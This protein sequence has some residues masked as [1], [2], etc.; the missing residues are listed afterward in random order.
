MRNILYKLVVIKLTLLFVASP[1]W[2]EN[3]N[4]QVMLNTEKG[5]IVVELFPKQAPITRG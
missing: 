1:S 4:P 5:D 3:N 2:T